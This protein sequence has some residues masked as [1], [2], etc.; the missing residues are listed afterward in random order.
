MLQSRLGKLLG[1]AAE[2]ELVLLSPDEQ[3]LWRVGLDP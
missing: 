2:E 1:R 3:R